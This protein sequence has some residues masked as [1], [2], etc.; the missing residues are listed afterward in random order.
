MKVEM[1][2]MKL[3]YLSLVVVGVLAN[4]VSALSMGLGNQTSAIQGLAAALSNLN[5]VSGQ[6]G[7]TLMRSTAVPQL[8]AT[9]GQART[10]P[11]K[12]APMI[13]GTGQNFDM[14]GALSKQRW[15]RNI[16]TND[17]E[18]FQGNLIGT[19]SMRFAGIA[20]SD[21]A[22]KPNWNS[23]MTTVP[24]SDDLSRFN[25]AIQVGPVSTSALLGI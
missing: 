24:G 15:L 20:E 6:M 12:S 3:K 14:T 21:R 16:N 17:F 10:R 7:S 13:L 8:Q 5:S 9:G 1:Q 22:V 25:P 11:A 18:R 4:P 2:K 23:T 19:P